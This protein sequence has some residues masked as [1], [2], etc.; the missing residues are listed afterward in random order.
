MSF[1]EYI[2]SITN[3]RFGI[4]ANLIDPSLAVA[5]SIL[6]VVGT[7]AVG[8][9]LLYAILPAY[10]K[11]IQWLP[12][13]APVV[14]AALVA[15][16]AHSLALAGLLTRSVAALIAISLIIVGVFA[17]TKSRDLITTTR[18][19]V[20]QQFYKLRIFDIALISALTVGLA[21][22]SL[23]LPTDD[24]TMAYH[25]GVAIA[26]L[27]SGH[28]PVAPEWFHSRLAGAGESLTAIGF[29][30]GA[31]QFLS[32]LQFTALIGLLTIVLQR[33][34]NENSS[35][36]R[37]VA[38]LSIVSIPILIAWSN[39]AKPLLLPVA[40]TTVSLAL[41]IHLY[42]DCLERKGSNSDYQLTGLIVICSLALMAGVFRMNHL[43]SGALIV[44]GAAILVGRYNNLL[45]S[46][47]IPI[48]AGAAIIL[49]SILWKA[50]HFNAS[51][52]AAAFT[53]LSGEFTGIN[54][55]IEFLRNYRDSNF[56]FPFNLFLPDGFRSITTVLGVGAVLPLLLIRKPTSEQTVWIGA[57][58]MSFVVIATSELLNSRFF[59]EPLLWA[60]I[61]VARQ[62]DPRATPYRSVIHWTTRAQA[63][64]VLSVVAYINAQILPGALSAE[65]RDRAMVKVANGYQEM[66]WA[67]RVL[68]EASRLLVTT[69]HMSL[70][71]RPAIS[72]EW[73][74]FVDPTSTGAA[75]YLEKIQKFQVEF[76]MFRLS[77][78]QTMDV[79]TCGASVFKI[80]PSFAKATRNPVNAGAAYRTWLI[81][82][83]TNT[84]FACL[85]KL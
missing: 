23:P 72:A 31:T 69:R 55:F 4:Y 8:K 35:L 40:M 29:A 1:V 46:L 2:S 47:L 79:T 76:A 73:R 13:Q 54:E 68:P 21:L 38:A 39:S 64:L 30:I 84:D 11:H 19:Q 37:S 32:I 9:W 48:V 57:A 77:P 22:L 34:D 83:S 25:F 66:M 20:S 45:K 15:W 24:D 42:R 60:L 78:N 41:T 52:P 14:G 56:V 75:T 62:S 58:T 36:T 50:Y 53:P 28:A 80:S 59:L 16:L 81:R 61:A 82:T 65:Q 5:M 10:I 44:L 7:A 3:V 43:P 67:D 12:F 70:A 6:L 26:T 49:P 27:N 51:L 63:V 71:P 33:L 17:V 74:R 18:S 85:L